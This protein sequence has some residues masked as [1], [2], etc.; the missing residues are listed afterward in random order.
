MASEKLSAEA[1]LARGIEAYQQGRL[2]EAA[3]HFGN[4]VAID[5]GSAQ[6]HLALGATRLTLYKRGC[7]HPSTNYFFS[8]REIS[9]DQWETYEQEENA[10]IIEQN[11]TNWP[12]AEKS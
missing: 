6:A 9:E 1:C 2:D 11:A 4:A 12:L 5:P 7:R 8:E 10:L 3:E